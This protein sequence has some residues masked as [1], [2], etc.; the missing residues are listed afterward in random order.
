VARWI[1]FSNA[2]IDSINI[3][4]GFFNSIISFFA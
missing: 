4:T 1:A 2:A 3:S